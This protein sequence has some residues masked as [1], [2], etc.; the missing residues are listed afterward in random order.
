MNLKRRGT[1]FLFIAFLN[2]KISILMNLK[3]PGTIFL[4][5]AFLNIKIS[6]LTNLKIPGTIFLFVPFLNIEKSILTN[7]KT[8]LFILIRMITLKETIYIKTIIQIDNH[9][10]KYIISACIPIII[11]KNFYFFLKKL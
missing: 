2:I 11:I 8:P 10:V 6:I 7:L 4:L 1:I 9:K 3:I 5:I